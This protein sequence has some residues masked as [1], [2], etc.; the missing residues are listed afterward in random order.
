MTKLY[1]TDF[2]LLP[3]TKRAVEE[4]QTDADDSSDGGG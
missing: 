4:E 3:R 2:A 1:T